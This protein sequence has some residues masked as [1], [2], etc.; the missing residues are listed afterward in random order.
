MQSTAI[1]DYLNS[2]KLNNKEKMI[3]DQI[4]KELNELGKEKQVKVDVNDIEF[5]EIEE[6][7][8]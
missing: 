4:L 5:T 2:L 6:E 8:D 3:A 7:N 1:K